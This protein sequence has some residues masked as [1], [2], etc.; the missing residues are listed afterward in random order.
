MSTTIDNKVVSMKFDNQHFEKNVATSMSTIDKLK[1]SLNFSGASKG[2]EEVNSAANKCDM[3]TLGKAAD[4]VR[5]KFSALEVMAVTALANITN[6]A[7]NAGKRIVSALTIDPIKTGFAEYET[8]I[9]AIQ[10]ILANTESKGTTLEDVN[11]ALDELNTYADKTIYNFTEMTRNIGTF[12]AAGV[13]LDTSVSAIKGIANLAAV[14][15]STSQQASTAMYQLSQALSSGTVKLMDWNSV[16]NAGMGGQVFQDALKETARVHGVAIDDLI[17]KEGSFRETLQHGWLSSEILT[18]TLS[19]FTGDLS[20][21]QL[22][23]MGY[24]EEQIKKIVKMGQTANDAATKVKTFS[25]LFDTLK[26]AAQSGWTQTWEL[27]VGDFEEAREMLTK[28]SDTIGKIIGDSAEAR[29]EL[30]ENWKV[31]GGRTALLDA[32]KNA[33]EGIVSIITPI[34]EA[35]RE[36]FPPMTAERL[37]A[38]TEGLRDLM[39]RLKLSDESSDNLKRTFKGLFA[40]I[41]IV[42]EAFV[43]IVKAGASLF[44][45]VGDVGGGILSVTAKIGDLLVKLSEWIKQ[46]GIFTTTFQSIAN[47]IKWVIQSLKT[48][49]SWIG[50]KILFPAWEGF[51]T[52]LEKLHE[53]LSGIGEASSQ[54]SESVKDAFSGMTSAVQSNPIIKI[55]SSLW[56]GIKAITSGLVKAFGKL[57]SGLAEKIGNGDFNGV[58][59]FLNGIISGG[60]GIAIIRFI[61]SLSKPLESL[62]DIGEGFADIIGGVGDCL[63]AFAMKVK[64]EALVKI[65]IAVAILAAALLV[66]SFIDRDK[67]FDA[68]STITML[69][70]ELM[71]SMSVFSRIAG[72]F[73][74]VTKACVAMISISLAVLIL[75]SA[76]KKISNLDFDEMVTGI[77][78]VAGLMAM[79]VA[80]IKILGRGEKAVIK[81]AFQMILFAA[82]IKILASACNDIAYLDWEDL[83]KGLLGIGVLMTEISLFINNTKFS[84][85]MFSTCAGI[86]L[87]AASMKILASVCEDFGLMSWK[88]ISKGLV[89]IGVLLAELALFTKLSGNAKHVISTGI[90]ILA[91]SAAMKIFA[92]AIEDLSYLS[93][94]ELTKGL[95][96]IAGAL[97]AVV[98]AVKLMPR[99]MVSMGIGLIA[100]A[101]ALLIMASALGKMGK[102]SWESIGKSLVTLGGAMV[103]LAIGLRAMTGTA[104]GSAS[105]LIAA[106]ALGI[107][108]PILAF[109]GAMSWGSIAKGLIVIAGAFT[110]IG[111]AALILKSVVPYILAL[112]AA[113]LL[114][115]VGVLAAG[116]GLLAFGAGLSGLAVGF[117]ALVGS[118]GVVVSGIVGLVSAVIVGIIKG[119]GEGIVALCE[120]IIEGIPAIGEAIKVTILTLCD[121]LSECAPPLADTILKV[122]LAILEALVR[123]T[124]E[125]VDRLFD[126]VI[127]VIEGLARNIPR[128]IEAIMNVIMSIFTGVIDAFKKLDFNTLMKGVGIVSLLAVM[129]APLAA[130][131]PMLPAAMAG[132]LGIGVIIGEIML[133]IAAIGVLAQMPGLE[134][135]INEGGNLLESLGTAIGKFIG[136]FAG[137]IMSGISG[138]FEQIGSDLSSFMINLKPFIDGA[139]EID[140]SVLEGVKS[141]VDII[142]ALTGA[143]VVDALASFFT[144]ES[145]LTKYGKELAEFGSC[146]KKYA[147]AVSGMDASAVDESAA[148]AK[149]LAEMS[150]VVP[151]SGGIVS[152][153]AGDNSV[154]KFGKELVELGKG[155]KGFSD[156]TKGTD[157]KNIEAAANAAKALAEMANVVPN[158]GG[159]VTWF[160]GDNSVADFAEELVTLGE[161]LK[162]FSDATIGVNPPTMTATAEAAKALAA[163]TESIPNEGGM[164]TW[165]AGDKSVSKFAE[166]LVELGKGLKGFSDVTMGVSPDTTTA[167]A[168][169]A[170]ALAEMANTI[171]NE[172]G[173][174]TWFAGDNS[175][176]KFSEELVELGK[177][178][179][180]FSDATMGINPESTTAA[181]NAAKALAEM[182]NIVPNSGGMVT[183]FTGDNSVAKFGEELVELGKGLKGFSDATIGINPTTTTAAANAGKALAEMANILPNSGGLASLFTGD[184][185]VDKFGDGLV[186]LGK[187]I[188]GFSD[189]TIGINPTTTTAAANAGKALAEMTNVIPDK[190]DKV[191]SFG[192]NLVSFGSNLGTYYSKVGNISVDNINRGLSVIDAVKNME[193]VID[194]GRVKDIANAI[195]DLTKALQGMSK[196]NSGMVSEFNNAMRKLGETST[197]TLIK[198]F[199]NLD[200]DMKKA[201]TNAVNAFA[202]A[203]KDRI[204][205]AKS[206]FKTL[207]SDCAAAISDQSGAFKSAGGDCVSGFANGISDNTYR[208]E[209]KARAMAKAALRAAEDELDINSPSKAFYKDGAFSGQG[210]VNGLDAYGDKSYA[211]GRTMAESA[212]SGLRDAISKIA[213]VINGDMDMQPTIR[214]V[215]DLSDV[216]SGAGAIGGI[217][218]SGSSIGVFSNVGAISV[219]MNR[220]AQNGANDD[221]VSAIDKLRADFNDMDRASYTIEGIT[222]G[223]GSDIAEALKT[224][225]RAA[226]IERR[227]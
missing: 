18:E 153:F 101:T 79:L 143:N 64:A 206:A 108:A 137:G 41:S 227:T 203:V 180:G 218:G 140:P 188:K 63:Q 138:Q 220:R 96:G 90:A 134:W 43:A 77:I 2:L 194:P 92:S 170:K 129:M 114:L 223:E 116:V 226:K 113:M 104:G 22:R 161:G 73:T 85:K 6:S 99:N 5:L 215:L 173:M 40:V 56:N 183:W 16:V 211:A 164:V 167:A 202:N 159:M 68:L 45:V 44:G 156:S 97:A 155:L 150:N 181:A 110:V 163:M 208:A 25:Q 83:A 200:D 10:T 120:V 74:G 111:V 62:A 166:E 191:V 11:G 135:L 70:T 26:E 46:S 112:S 102:M 124:P 169:S 60:I 118:L 23:S 32:I 128:I 67:L 178:L 122:V 144:G 146:L 171:P 12:T 130:V 179:K 149:A 117:V 3:S 36:I 52:L 35:F 196:I 105:L 48:V 126:F 51:H 224:I 160:A 192:K 187:G 86:V 29:N 209:A 81:G 125:I 21:E 198:E 217:L 199:E 185:S 14:S 7:V 131:G 39:A 75:A 98:I 145:S 225:V 127:G 165:F 197:D 195:G 115:G 53:M 54:M 119:V 37:V 72:K 221:V 87:L 1:K 82:A 148:S 80:T 95:V 100:V 55:L 91:I 15:G 189:A 152:W 147:D 213:K 84:G 88:E 176:A 121:V 201:A 190:T 103:I 59:D 154:A 182:S 177:G 216:K 58:L 71:V 30:I 20:E 34:K 9:N 210:F 222:Y 123:Y 175:V 109:L 27:I 57:A 212:K 47:V 49:I 172:G 38:L 107:F 78:G 69:F 151:N 24:T 157:P 4:T 33:F 76:L 106:V 28:V 13:D 8:Q 66:I 133:I 219:M 42:K 65:A 158:S 214:P 205:T 94:E 89:S 162:G 141:I 136:G 142:L 174:V 17:K 19:K 31:L 132:V 168:N 207:V 204:S 61:N 50:K 193:D 186:E 139:K 184:K 93:W